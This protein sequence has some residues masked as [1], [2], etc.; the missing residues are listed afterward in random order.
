[1]STMPRITGQ[2]MIDKSFS[3]VD[4]PNDSQGFLKIY[5]KIGLFNFLSSVFVFNNDNI[6][7]RIYIDSILV[8]E[9]NKNDPTP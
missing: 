8:I 5:E 1:M 7:V 6:D 9:F 2:Y 3:V 4:L